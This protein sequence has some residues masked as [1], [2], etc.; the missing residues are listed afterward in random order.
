MGIG[1]PSEHQG[2]I[3]PGKRSRFTQGGRSWSLYT[4]L[5]WHRPVSPTLGRLMLKSYVSSLIYSRERP[6]L[7]GVIAYTCDPSTQE[8]KVGAGENGSA[9]LSTHLVPHN[10]L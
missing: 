9:V 6:C 8:I 4:L 2:W 3:L 5:G 7:P 10:H 1:P